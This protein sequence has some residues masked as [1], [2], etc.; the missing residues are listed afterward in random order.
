MIV[1]FFT[2]MDI[3]ISYILQSQLFIPVR[4]HACVFVCVCVCVCVHKRQCYKNK[5]KK[6]IYMICK[7][8]LSI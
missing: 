4:V 2:D 6:T 8:V 7:I 5:K 1:F 3:M